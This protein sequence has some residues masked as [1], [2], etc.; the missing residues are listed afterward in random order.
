MLNRVDLIGL[1]ASRAQRVGADGAGLLLL[2]QRDDRGLG[3][4]RH[5]VIAEPGS[6]ADLSVFAPGETAYISGR[7]GRYDQTRRVAV[8]ARE[9]WSLLP[10]PSL[11]SA[12]AAPER[13]HAS[14]APHLRRGH[15]R[16]V[17]RG[18]ARERV[19][20]VRPARVGRPPFPE[21]ADARPRASA[22]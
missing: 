3:V 15:P 7:L 11:V 2:T 17:G 6:G 12:A 16:I 13:S 1:V 22:T 20:W 21:L 18:T 19:V 4:D 9:A 14:P 10:A 8:I 5:R